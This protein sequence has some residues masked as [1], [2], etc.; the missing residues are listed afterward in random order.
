MNSTSQHL[1]QGHVDS[2]NF[3]LLKQYSSIRDRSRLNTISEPHAG[4][5]LT[6]VPNPNLGLVM[7]KH[8]FTIA[9]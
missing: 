8:E 3:D 5:W 9:V 7:S 2:Q 1:L 6:A 4:A